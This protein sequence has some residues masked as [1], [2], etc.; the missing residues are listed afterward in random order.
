MSLF[1]RLYD[2]VLA[3]WRNATYCAALTQELARAMPVAQR[4]PAGMAYLAGL[5]SRFGYLL[6]GHL[7]PAQF[8]LLNHVIDANRDLGVRDVEKYVLG[9]SHEQIG[10]WLLQSWRMP[11]ELVTAVRYQHRADYYGSHAA[12]AGLNLIANRLLKRRGIGYASHELL[13]SHVL[14]ALGISET[15]AMERLAR[16]MEQGEGVESLAHQLAA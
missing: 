7:F 4:P 16:V 2:L 15:E 3:F 12:Y 9:V 10:G 5:L 14:Q 11:E 8:F 1:E 13:P 6:L